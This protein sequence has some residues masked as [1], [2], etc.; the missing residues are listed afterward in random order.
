MRRTTTAAT[1]TGMMMPSADELVPAVYQPQEDT[2]LLMSAVTADLVAG[3]RVLDLCT[4]SGALAVHAARLGAES[5]TAVDISPAAVAAV[6]SGAAAAGVADRVQ[7]IE[8]GVDCLDLQE[9]FDV[10]TCNPPYLPTPHP[11]EAALHPPGPAH[12]WDGGAD[13]RLVLDAV[14]LQAHALLRPGGSLFVVQ[15]EFA[16]IPKTVSGCVDSRLEW[17]LVAEQFIAFGPVVSARARWFERL[18]LLDKGRQTERIAVVRADKP[19][20]SE[21]KSA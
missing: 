17:K 3:R 13:G 7:A 12:C 1:S 14:C 8:G 18:G 6:T 21:R 5:V 9:P 20:V 2:F 4:G 16:D 11:A 15:S 19:V 10:V